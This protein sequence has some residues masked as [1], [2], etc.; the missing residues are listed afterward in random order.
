MDNSIVIPLSVID[1]FG[2]TAC[3]MIYGYVLKSV[4][5]SKLKNALFAVADKWRLL[6]GRIEWDSATQMYRIRVPLGDLPEDYARATFTRAEYPQKVLDTESL[7]L[8]NNSAVFLSRPPPEYFRHSST[9]DGLGGFATRK[10]PL[11][12]LHVSVLKNCI[13]VG[14]VFTHGAFDATG[15][16]LVARA[17]NDEF[18]G[19]AWDPFALQSVNMITKVVDSTSADPKNLT[20]ALCR[21]QASVVP[22]GLGSVATFVGNVL[23]EKLWQQAERR[24]LFLGNSFVDQIV[25]SV[26]KQ[27]AEEKRGFVSTGD[28]LLAWVI[29]VSQIEILIRLKR[30]LIP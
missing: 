14:L 16:G 30:A 8:D 13:C 10:L 20:P 9:P 19:R 29:Q 24:S 26:K 1:H 28:V 25:N 5:E 17:F 21:L 2:V 4:D 11:L 22:M 18:N 7:T 23:Y 27:V 3:S 12:S 6:A 15:M